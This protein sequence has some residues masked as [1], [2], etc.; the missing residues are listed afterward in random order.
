MSGLPIP[1]TDPGDGVFPFG[2][3]NTPRP[4]RW[5]GSGRARQ[6]ILG[7]YPSALHIVWTPPKGLVDSGRQRIAALAVDVE[8][9]VFWNGQGP[10]PAEAIAGW[11]R[12]V[13]FNDRTAGHGLARLAINGASGVTLDSYFAGLPHP[14]TETVLAD[15]YPVFLVKRSTGARWHQG[16]VQD[17]IY[18]R[19]A[20]RLP[21]L[22]D[23]P[24]G[25]ATLPSRLPPAVLSRQAAVRFGAWLVELIRTVGPETIVTL[26][27]EP[28][29]TLAL[30][31]ELTCTAPAAKLSA[32]R[33]AGYGRPG[34]ITVDGRRITWIPLAHPGLIQGPSGRR[35]TPSWVEAHQAWIDAPR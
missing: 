7:V 8:P 3:P 19:I 14:V 31:P 18:N 27:Q 20:G 2:R 25:P 1:P 12:A 10:T 29:D 17:R 6:L 21:P 16:D 9:T 24:V 35:G 33:V 5:D 28:W 13:G 23:G 34:T 4:A 32:S 26:G 15:V 11:K 30:L 22:A